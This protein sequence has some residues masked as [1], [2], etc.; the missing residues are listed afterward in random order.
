ME[1]GKEGWNTGMNVIKRRTRS[2]MEVISRSGM[3]VISRR[4]GMEVISRRSGMEVISRRSG[5]EIN[6][7]RRSGTLE[8]KL[9]LKEGGLQYCLNLYTRYLVLM[10][11]FET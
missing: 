2:G 5:M 11:E 8:R 4:S 10:R 9:L 6:S 1:V 3:E 7:K